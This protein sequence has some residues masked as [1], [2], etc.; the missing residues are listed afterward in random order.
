MRKEA[1]AV[2]AQCPS[3]SAFNPETPWHGGPAPRRIRPTCEN[4]PAH[5]LTM[6]WSTRVTS[7]TK[8]VSANAD[9]PPYVPQVIF[10]RSHALPWQA[11]E[12]T[13]HSQATYPIKEPN[14]KNL[15]QVMSFGNVTPYHGICRGHAVACKPVDTQAPPPVEDASLAV[16]RFH[17]S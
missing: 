3:L 6:S 2:V 9:S 17:A 10:R 16:T 13:C 8:I 15:D 12:V 1:T 11:K 5:A 14:R 4:L 7:S